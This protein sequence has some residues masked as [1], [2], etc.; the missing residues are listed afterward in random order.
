MPFVQVLLTATP[1]NLPGGVRRWAVLPVEPMARI[2][3]LATK[4][5]AVAEVRSDRA[6][7]HLLLLVPTED[8]HLDKLRARV[9][10]FRDSP[11]VDW[12]PP[13]AW[14][15]TGAQ[16]FDVAPEQEQCPPPTVPKKRTYYNLNERWNF[17]VVG[18]TVNITEDQPAW[19]WDNYQVSIEGSDEL[20]L[21]HKSGAISRYRWAAPRA[22]VIELE[23]LE[24][25][26]LVGY[27]HT[28]HFAQRLCKAIGGIR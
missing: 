24:G 3:A 20:T 9:D 18:F 28:R 11:A 17:D 8:V 25:P 6:G 19:D 22:N 23:L 27:K 14:A 1:H 21:W 15:L 10:V 12:E 13:T 2:I 26:G 4:E 16:C 5:F 7:L